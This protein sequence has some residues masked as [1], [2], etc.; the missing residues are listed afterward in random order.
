MHKQIITHCHI[1]LTVKFLVVR[2]LLYFSAFRRYS[3][4][5]ATVASNSLLA[6]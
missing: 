4:R 5:N 2:S 1:V 3:P 6:L